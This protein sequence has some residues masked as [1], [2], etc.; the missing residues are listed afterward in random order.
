LVAKPYRW[1]ARIRFVDTDA[2]QRIHYTAM[3]RHFEAAEHDFLDSIGCPYTH[4]EFREVSFPRVHV[5]CDFFSEIRY[6]DVIEIEMT[7]D[8]VGPSSFTM[9]FST[10]VGGRSA[11]KGRITVVC[12]DRHTQR[13]CPIPD[14]LAGCLREHLA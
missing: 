13:S 5:E 1:R 6:D 14:R 8:R 3:F 12:I 10:T 2:S 11:A 9:Q 7:V 4:P